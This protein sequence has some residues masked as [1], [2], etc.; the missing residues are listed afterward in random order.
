MF[1]CTSRV[2]VSRYIFTLVKIVS[3]C[4]LPSPLRQDGPGVARRAEGSKS[5]RVT[6]VQGT[7]AIQSDAFT[8]TDEK[9]WEIAM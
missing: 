1:H 4:R 8:Q 6:N 2:F 3:T 5:R 7:F 9:S